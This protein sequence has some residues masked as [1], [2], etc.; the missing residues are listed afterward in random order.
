M[1]CF[2]LVCKQLKRKTGVA[3]SEVE[4]ADHNAGPGNVIVPK[5]SFQTPP[6]TKSGKQKVS[7]TKASKAGS[8]IPMPNVG[9]W[10]FDQILS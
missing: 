6:S 2:F 7:R 5:G 9:K 10:E 1:A 3:E 4:P 8:Q